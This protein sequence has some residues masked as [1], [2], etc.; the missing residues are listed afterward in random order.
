MTVEMIARWQLAVTSFLKT[1]ILYS[2][3][4]ERGIL[5]LSVYPCIVQFGPVLNLF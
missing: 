2:R 4:W 5:D 3:A 1:A